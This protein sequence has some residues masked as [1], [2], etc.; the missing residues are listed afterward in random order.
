MVPDAGL[1]RFTFTAG[2]VYF[3]SNPKND[4]GRVYL[5]VDGLSAASNYVYP[6]SDRLE[7]FVMT[8]NTVQN[9][10]VGQSVSIEWE[11]AGSDAHINDDSLKHTHWT[12]TYLGSGSDSEHT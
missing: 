3:P 7:S 1:W 5:K 10:E 8:M 12:G 11:N 4:S 9:L 2:C 6:K